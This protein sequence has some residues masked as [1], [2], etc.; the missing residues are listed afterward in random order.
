MSLSKAT[1]SA[2]QRAGQAMQ[3]ATV[4]VSNAVRQQ[5][6]HMVATVANQPFQA[7]GDRAFSNFKIFA[8]LSQDL[9]ML[10]EKLQDL[11][12]TASE[13]TDPEM[14]VV[15]LPKLHVRIGG[16][17]EDAVVKPIR[18]P[19]KRAG[20]RAVKGPLKPV[21]LSPN[22]HK[23]LDFLKS[24]LKTDHAVVITNEAIAKGAGMPLG[25]VGI[26]LKRVM[27]FGAIKKR[28]RSSY[29]LSA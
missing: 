27:A 5:A 8:R 19:R 22:D 15:A 3:Q 28:G 23:V 1:V 10:E 11:Y 20:K 17:A 6:E 12:S 18:T 24:V 7:E 25:S 4:V 13:L 2:I 16:M 29:Q 26:S 14:D 21:K 9:H